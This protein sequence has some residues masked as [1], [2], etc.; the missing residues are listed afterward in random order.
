MINE[1]I[2]INLKENPENLLMMNNN[3]MRIMQTMIISI[4]IIITLI[5][6]REHDYVFDNRSLYLD[7][8]RVCSDVLFC[9]MS[10]IYIN[11]NEEDKG[12]LKEK[13][14]THFFVYWKQDSL[15]RE[16]G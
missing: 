1:Y 7:P 10:Y 6:Q 14:R 12:I 9:P 15:E 13:M 4:I 8:W 5:V 2:T 3:I 11:N 16:N